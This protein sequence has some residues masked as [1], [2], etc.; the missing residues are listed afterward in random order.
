MKSGLKAAGEE[1]AY[2]VYDGF[3]GIMVQP[4]IGARDN[5]ALGFFKGIGM[6]LTGFVL[7][8]LA[9]IIAPF[10]YTFKGMH[11]ELLKGKQPTNF[12]RKAH[13]IQGQRDLHVLDDKEKATIIDTVNHGWLAAQQIWATVEAKSA[14][15]LRGKLHVMRACRTWRTNGALEN[16][17][18]ADG[19]L[20]AARG[21]ESLDAISEQQ[22]G[23]M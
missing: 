5:G 11:K 3:T 2:G 10:G 12:I 8:D 6:G 4:Y 18:M 1:F 22:R 21:G 23:H 19:A 14:Q 17:E 13:I 9:A 20:K 15:G 16:V 7:K